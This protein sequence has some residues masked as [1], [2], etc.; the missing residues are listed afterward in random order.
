M[1]KVCSRNRHVGRFESMKKNQTCKEFVNS[2]AAFLEDELTLQD[3]IRAQKHLSSCD[4][5]SA[6]FRGY[7]RTIGLAKKTGSNNA[8]SAILPENLVRKIMGARRRS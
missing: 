7:E 6:Y 5:C 3:R 2:L 1:A 4:K 8:V